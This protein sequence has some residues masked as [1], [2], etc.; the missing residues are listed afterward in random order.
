[1]SDPSIRQ[2]HSACTTTIRIKSHSRVKRGGKP[3]IT[4]FRRIAW[5]SFLC[6]KLITASPFQWADIATLVGLKPPRACEWMST[7]PV[8][9]RFP[10]FPR[11]TMR[12]TGVKIHRP[13]SIHRRKWL[14]LKAQSVQPRNALHSRQHDR[15]PS[16]QRCRGNPHPSANA[17]LWSS[18]GIYRLC[19]R[20]VEQPGLIQHM[21]VCTSRVCS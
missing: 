2:P 19:G 4:R 3:K 9:R 11:S 14:R 21:F 15:R 12:T 16:R 7:C 20:G 13:L 10:L 8:V 6:P 17:W 18:A 1:M 5:P